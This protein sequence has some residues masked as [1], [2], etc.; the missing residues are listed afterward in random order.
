M[1]RSG[2]TV[3]LGTAP[4]NA[5]PAWR[6]ASTTGPQVPAMTCSQLLDG[7][8]SEPAAMETRCQRVSSLFFASAR[9]PATRPCTSMAP[10]IAPALVP[11]TTWMSRSGSSR[12][13][14][15]TPQVKA[16]SAPPPSRASVTGCEA[17]ETVSIGSSGRA[18]PGWDWSVCAEP[19]LCFAA[20][21]HNK[22]RSSPAVSALQ[23]TRFAGRPADDRRS[24]K[25]DDAK[26]AL[27]FKICAMK[28]EKG[29][30]SITMLRCVTGSW[31]GADA[32]AVVMA[33]LRWVAAAR[34]DPTLKR[35]AASRTGDGRRR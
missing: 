32:T 6:T 5:E 15:R 3:K 13:R 7:P 10:F 29:L 27:G 20:V 4:L 22:P 23:G 1:P 19:G 33:R 35:A 24:A 34:L 2:L 18:G 14:S 12:S 21:Q 16:P 26:A 31:P 11:L 8:G 28:K 9:P 17:V 25:V 30:V